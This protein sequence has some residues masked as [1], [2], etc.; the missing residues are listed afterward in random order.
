MINSPSERSYYSFQ[1]HLEKK[2]CQFTYMQTC[3]DG[4]VIDLQVVLFCQCF[5]NQLLFG[6][7]VDK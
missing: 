1:F 3:D 7:E 5:N 6:R 2:R 4:Q